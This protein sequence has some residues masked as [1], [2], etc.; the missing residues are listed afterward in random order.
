MEK[1]S[2]LDQINKPRTALE[3][4]IVEKNEAI[5]KTLSSKL[6]TVYHLID[7]D[8]N[9][10][11]LDLNNTLNVTQVIKNQL[12]SPPKE[13]ST[14]QSELNDN[15]MALMSRLPNTSNLVNTFL[16]NVAAN[17]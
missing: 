14:N 3:K 13:I 7:V 6:M 1:D 17:K 12:I 15:L 5:R 8:L 4:K 9:Q 11:S 16:V 10:I 2:S